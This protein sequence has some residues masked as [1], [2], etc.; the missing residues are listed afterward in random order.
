[1]KNLYY[2]LLFSVI[3]MFASCSQDMDMTGNTPVLKTSE[4]YHK[5]Y[6]FAIKKSKENPQTRAIVIDNIY[7]EEEPILWE[8][9]QTINIA[10]LTDR[11]DVKD[12]VKAVAAEWLNYA[13]LKFNYVNDPAEAQVK[14]QVT[15]ND[16]DGDNIF[17]SFIGKDCLYFEDDPDQ[18]TMNLVLRKGD[19]KEINSED[20]SAAVLREFGHVL[21]L[22]Y[23]HQGPNRDL[24]LDDSKVERYLTAQG[25]ELWD[26]GSFLQMYEDSQI[27]YEDY[28]PQSIMLAYFPDFLTTDG[29]GSTWNTKLSDKDKLYIAKVYPTP[30]PDPYEKGNEGNVYMVIPTGYSGAYGLRGH[31]Y[32]T[33]VSK[34]W[35]DVEGTYRTIEIGEYVWTVDN[36]K[37]KYW[38]LWSI[39]Y[40]IMNHSQASVNAATGTTG[41]Y[42]PQDFD[43]I[44]GTWISDYIDG[45]AYRNPD[46]YK[47]YQDATKKTTVDGFNLPVTNDILQLIGQAPVKTGNVYLDFCDF[48]YAK[49]ND[50]EYS[51]GRTGSN[52]SGLTI[53][54]L[55][56]KI[57]LPDGTG[58]HYSFGY[59]VG[60]KMKDNARMFIFS[61]AAGMQVN[62]NLY[63]FSQAR[64]CKK[65]T[66]LNYKLYLNEEKDEV[67]MVYNDD[68]KTDVSGLP[69]LPNGLERGIA[70]RYANRKAGIV[71]EPWSKIKEE[72]KRIK[73]SVGVN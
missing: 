16:P 53:T 40:T 12:K 52:I 15:I 47:F 73:N 6:V 50:Y 7:G 14:I 34:D 45:V 8:A 70:L 44:L 24:N 66:D 51:F 72:A 62:A 49:P 21:G 13:Y 38:A 65:K 11:Q 2:I 23:E 71:C 28:D 42:T 64:Y 48:V 19:A 27:A 17:W 22:G 9:G 61:D 58:Q 25:W 33:G 68:K 54:A 59:G 60:L 30:A 26:I 18:P 67:L 29:K 43:K 57:N 20:F 10:I 32:D 31:N 3:A 4:D 5:D 39:D 41:K 63:H 46:K 69:E 56:F 37:L 35:G 36:L 1:M 55:G